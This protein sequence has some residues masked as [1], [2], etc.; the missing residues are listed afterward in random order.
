MQA[1]V[2]LGC[3]SSQSFIEGDD[4]ILGRFSSQ[5]FIEGDDVER[6]AL[7]SQVFEAAL[8]RAERSGF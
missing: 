6:K 5:S 1:C 3:F 4:V 2:I 8:H 7:E